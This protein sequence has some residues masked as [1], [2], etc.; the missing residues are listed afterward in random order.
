MRI[1]GL[2]AV[3]WLALTAAVAPAD[4]EKRVALVIGNDHYANL[5]AHE[6]L[7]KAVND[8]RAVGG[9][10]RRIGFEVIAGENL[11]RQ[12]L[13]SRLDEAAQRLSPGDT[14][15]FFFSGHG[16]ALDGFNYILPADVPVVG[17]AQIAS[18]TGAAVKEE[19]ITAVFQRAG[20]RVA[21]VVLD[22]CRNNPFASSGTRGIGGEKG[23]APHEPPSGVFTF[24]SAGRG[25]AA[26]DRLYD[27]DA[28]PNS[29]FTRVLLPALT[30]PDLDLSGLAIE[31]REEVT[32]LART[33]RHDQ[34][35]AYYDETSG[36]RIY[37]AATGAASTPGARPG[38]PPGGLTPPPAAAVAPAAG[39]APTPAAPAV[40]PAVPPP[41]GPPPGVSAPAGAQQAA[42][43]APA[44]LGKATLIQ[45][46]AAV[47]RLKGNHGVS[48]QWIW[49]NPPGRL[50]VTESDGVIHL[51]G[52]Q[53]GRNGA[54]RLVLSGDVVSIDQFN[55]TFKGSISMYDAPSDRKECLRNGVFNFRITGS[56]KYWRLQEME[57]CDG[58]TDYVD[59][60]F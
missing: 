29:V 25:E 48:L 27:G 34:R 46:M 18:L 37:L 57:A 8:A 54:G 23:L 58:L 45:D 4:A 59:I 39:N 24:Y 49:N 19:D 7:Q 32:R 15:F 11:G 26:L 43:A 6:Q 40:K 28:D 36:G 1:A 42:V 44:A 50:N 31:V 35:P 41:S 16:V 51:D 60:F 20:A 12:A 10:L 17:S 5:A 30:R 33:V 22:A 21:V 47:R 9:A 38:L 56:R 3:A 52:S 53:L 2:I 14:A 55:M 13:L